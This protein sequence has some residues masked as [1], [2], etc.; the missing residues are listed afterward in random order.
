MSDDLKRR[1]PEDP[2]KINVNQPW[3]LNYWANKFNV[4]Q[5][6]IEKAVEEV[7]VFADEVKKHL[8]K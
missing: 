3:E 1:G 5:S 4:S 8:Q 2:K 6:Q 7:G